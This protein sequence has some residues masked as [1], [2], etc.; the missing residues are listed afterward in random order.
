MKIL[1]TVKD[2]ILIEFQHTKEGI[3]LP[4]TDQD[5]EKAEEPLRGFVHGPRGTGK[6]RVILWI[7][8][9]FTEALQWEHGLEFIFVAFQNRVAHAMGG[10][11][12]H[13]GGDITVGGQRSTSLA[14]TDIDN[15]F[16][17]NQHVRWLLIDEIGMIPDE[18]L[19]A[20]EAHF[21]EAAV[22][23]RYQERAHKSKR[24]FGG[25]N[26]L[27]FGDLFQIP[28]IPSSASICIPI[29]EKSQSTRAE[30]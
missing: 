6:S 22:S 1:L 2:R 30:H 12:L 26:M 3:M 17:R 24:P 14:H 29:R 9:L 15:L 13:T 28:P 21:T 10:T 18:L 7:R 5:R 20:F 25:Y 27:A 4:K 8:R 16:T 19:G 23:S 11:T